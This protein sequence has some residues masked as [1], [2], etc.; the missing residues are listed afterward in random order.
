MKTGSYGDMFSKM[1]EDGCHWMYREEFF[2]LLWPTYKCV[3]METRVIIN[4]CA[5]QRMKHDI[6]P[7]TTFYQ[8]TN[9]YISKRIWRMRDMY[10]IVNGKYGKCRVVCDTQNRLRTRKKY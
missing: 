3:W 10:L 4:G 7:K 2:M 9:M 8:I 1:I 5:I 6:L